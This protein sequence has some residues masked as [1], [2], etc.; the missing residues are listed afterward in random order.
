MMSLPVLLRVLAG[1]IVIIALVYCIIIFL[2][3]RPRLSVSS[4]L[5]YRTNDKDNK[6]YI[7]P[8]RITSNST[9]KYHDIDISLVVPCWNETKRLGG[10]LE[11]AVEY[12]ETNHKNKYE[13]LIVDDGSSDGTSEYAINKAHELKLTPHTLR[14][15]QLAKNRG[16][17][18]A[19]AHGFLHSRGK[20]GLFADADGASRFSDISKLIEF[21]ETIKDG[22]I[23]AISIGSRHHMIN[24]ETVVKRS[25]IRQVLMYGLK[26]LVFVFGV[27]DVKDTQCGFKMFNF[28]ATKR[29]FPHLHNERW[30]FD[31]EVLILAEI[32]G[33]KLKEIPVNWQEMDGS[34]VDLARDSI[35][36]A[37]DLVVTRLAYMFRIY[38]MDECGRINKKDD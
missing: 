25:F 5:K 12:L 11:E 30:I 33:M 28:E 20:W 26:T 6:L 23:P 13:I 1:A 19:V 16:K 32:Q 24:T 35:A 14:V 17:G 9:F 34:K 4:E 18:G 8:P 29:I 10:M 37:I 27:Q 21:Q 36:M 15:I 2:S 7:L 38:K 22:S 31:I 3:H